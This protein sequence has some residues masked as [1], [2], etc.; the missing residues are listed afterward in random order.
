MEAKDTVMETWMPDHKQ[1]AEAQAEI[2]FKAGIREAISVYGPYIDL[3]GQEIDTLSPL[4]IAHGWRSIRFEAGKK[5][6]EEIAKLKESK[7]KEIEEPKK[8]QFDKPDGC[9]ALACYNERECDSRDKKGNPKY[10]IKRDKDD[11]RVGP[12]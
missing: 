5:C 2:S 3:L 4:A 7:L 6:R 1:I 12:R 8:C 10:V 9:H 11:M